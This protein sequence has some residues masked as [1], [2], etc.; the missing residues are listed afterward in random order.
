MECVQRGTSFLGS[1]DRTE[2]GVQANDEGCEKGILRRAAS[3]AGGGPLVL[4][5]TDKKM[6]R[7]RNEE[8]ARKKKKKKK[9]NKEKH[10]KRRGVQRTI[11]LA[12]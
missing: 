7:K 1:G 10:T 2:G 5:V 3:P 6:R 11:P 12:G 8:G 4:V 9:K